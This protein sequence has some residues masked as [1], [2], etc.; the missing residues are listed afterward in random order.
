MPTEEFTPGEDLREELDE[1]KWIV[2]EFADIIGR[3]VEA[4]SDILNENTEITADT[5]SAFGQTLGTSADLW[6]NLQAVFRRSNQ[7]AP[8][9]P[10]S[11]AQ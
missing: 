4:A 11:D 3:P 9:S 1:R 10:Q 2:P 8:S 7:A 6:M 5:A